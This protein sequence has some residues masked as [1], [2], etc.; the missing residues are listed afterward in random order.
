MLKIRAEIDKEKTKR[1]DKQS[2][3]ISLERLKQ[4]TLSGKTDQEKNQYSTNKNCNS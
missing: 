2:K 4:Q 1:Q 3:N